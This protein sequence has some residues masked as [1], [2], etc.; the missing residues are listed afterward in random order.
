MRDDSVRATALLC[1]R[2]R[3]ASCSCVSRIALATVCCALMPCEMRAMT[4]RI[5]VPSCARRTQSGQTRP[6][7]RLPDGRPIG[8]S[9][10]KGKQKTTVF[11]FAPHSSRRN[12]R[13]C[14]SENLVC[15]QQCK[16]DT[17]DH[18]QQTSRLGRHAT[19]LSCLSVSRHSTQEARNRI[20]IGH[21]IRHSSSTGYYVDN[22]GASKR[23][24]ACQK[25]THKQR[26]NKKRRQTSRPKK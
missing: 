26:A 1:V 24:V 9:K 18:N 10:E 11:I 15:K 3:V 13:C 4:Q 2:R 22:P 20:R 17:T 12:W 16:L 8:D 19:A 6:V 21:R 5:G 7:S 23:T 25:V 14:A